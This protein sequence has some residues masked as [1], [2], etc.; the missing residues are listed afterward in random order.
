MAKRLLPH[1]GNKVH[2][3][4]KAPKEDYGS[5]Y[6]GYWEHRYFKQFF[7]ARLMWKVRDKQKQSVYDMGT[8]L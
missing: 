8:Q 3:N 7:G 1:W 5:I 6:S 2:G 4:F